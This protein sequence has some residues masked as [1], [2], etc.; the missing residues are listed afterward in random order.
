[1]KNV[2]ERRNFVATAGNPCLYT[3]FPGFPCRRRQHLARSIQG[4]SRIILLRVWYEYGSGILTVSLPHNR[5]AAP[6]A[7]E[8]AQQQQGG[9][10]DVLRVRYSTR[11]TRISTLLVLVG[12]QSAYRMVLGLRLLMLYGTISIVRYKVSYTRTSTSTVIGTRP[13]DTAVRL[14]FSR[15]RGAQ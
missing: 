2:S 7:S 11:K 3:C 8:R 6:R 15:S 9:C 4:L 10:T 12:T 5:G 1:M 13:G 14:S